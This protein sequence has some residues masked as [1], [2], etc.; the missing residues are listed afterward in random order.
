MEEL[1]SKLQAERVD[2]VQANGDLRLSLYN[3]ASHPAK[4]PP[5]AA[6]IAF[7]NCI[8]EE[9]GGLVLQSSKQ[10]ASYTSNLSLTFGKTSGYAIRAAIS[11][12]DT[13]RKYGYT[14][15]QA[16]TERMFIG[17][18]AGAIVVRLMDSRGK[19][20]I[21]VELDASGESCLTILDADGN[22]SNRLNS[23]KWEG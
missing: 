18:D 23:L 14:V 2:I 20:R 9:F 15:F 11:E 10:G 1:F 6:G 4:L 19:V 5:G 12:A 7:F 13:Q 21:S 16:G 8:G 22:A 3:S 17:K